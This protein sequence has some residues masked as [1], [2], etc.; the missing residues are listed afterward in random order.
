MHHFYASLKQ[1]LQYQKH[2]TW[3]GDS[4]YAIVEYLGTFPIT[5]YHTAMPHTQQPSTYVL[6]KNPTSFCNV[7]VSWPWIFHAFTSFIPFNSPH[8][9]TY[10]AC[11]TGPPVYSCSLDYWLTRLCAAIIHTASQQ[12]Q[13][14]AAALS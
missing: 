13:F 11:L 10:D 4:P 8:P 12:S 3:I 9:S 6:K 5:S 2:V 1:D 14:H 7:I